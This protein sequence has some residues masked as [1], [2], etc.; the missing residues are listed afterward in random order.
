MYPWHLPD[1]WSYIQV[2]TLTTI[3]QPTVA[4]SC[5][6]S[7]ECTE[8]LL[9]PCLWLS[10]KK[11]SQIISILCLHSRLWRR[12][13][14]R[15]RLWGCF[16]RTGHVS[17]RIRYKLQ[18]ALLQVQAGKKSRTSLTRYNR[19]NQRSWNCYLLPSC[20]LS[21]NTRTENLSNL[22]P[23]DLNKKL[24]RN[25]VSCNGVS[26]GRSSHEVASGWQITF[27]DDHWLGSGNGCLTSCMRF[28]ACSLTALRF[29]LV[30]IRSHLS[31]WEYLHLPYLH[32]QSA[33]TSIVGI[34][35][36]YCV[37]LSICFLFLSIYLSTYYSALSNLLKLLAA[38]CICQIGSVVKRLDLAILQTW[39]LSG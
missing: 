25:L 8:Y 16:N 20:L 39:G 38:S 12:L 19:Y 34:Y 31:M 1:L 4:D 32:L 28:T 13:Y 24:S 29:F 10:P 22:N 2:T 18:S 17:L 14:L 27:L 5:G 33:C 3:L 7:Y 26:L 35:C 15:F 37:C 9:W 30:R 23:T 36:V 21:K 6:V 11:M